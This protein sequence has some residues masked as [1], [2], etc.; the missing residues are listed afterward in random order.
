MHEKIV[1]IRRIS[2]I[3]LQTLVFEIE[4]IINNRPI[5]QDYDNEL[6]NVLTPNHLVYGRRLENVNESNSCSI[7]VEGGVGLSKRKKY[8]DS[9]LT[10]FWS[11][12]RKEYLTSLRESQKIS[13]IQ[14]EKNLSIDDVVIVYDKHQPRHLWKLARV[15]GLIK[16]KDNVVRG[17]TIKFGGSGAVTTRPL[18]KLYLLEARKIDKEIRTN[19]DDIDNEG[20]VKLNEWI[21]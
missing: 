15:I 8:L 14:G 4:A 18:N 1:G 7:E 16:G 3:E 10:Y 6:E 12:W 19:E 17:A 5:C 20:K 2:Y 9:L 21:T 13:N 11:I